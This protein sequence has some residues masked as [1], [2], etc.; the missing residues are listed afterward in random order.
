V[1]NSPGKVSYLPNDM[2]NDHGNA[3]TSKLFLGGRVIE[4]NAMLKPQDE[5]DKIEY[6]KNMGF[7]DSNNQQDGK[8]TNL[9]NYLK[10]LKNNSKVNDISM[11]IDDD[12]FTT[13]DGSLR[14]HDIKGSS[15]TKFRRNRKLF[16]D[17]NTIKSVLG[18]SS[19]KYHG[20][21]QDY[22]KGGTY[23]NEVASNSIISDINGYTKSKLS[24]NTF[25]KS[26]GSLDSNAPKRRN[27]TDKQDALYNTY[28]QKGQFYQFIFRSWKQL[29]NECR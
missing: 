22:I 15:P 2:A 24:N 19:G 23:N 13:N 27:G 11:K 3:Y 10:K 12:S 7:Y 14:N 8:S 28:A 18:Q 21:A 1:S 9:H 5:N 25:L 29:K 16:I 4:K 26:S 17:R 20:Y 6:F